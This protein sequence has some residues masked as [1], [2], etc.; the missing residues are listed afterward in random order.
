MARKVVG[1]YIMIMIR[2]LAKN[3][4]ALTTNVNAFVGETQALGMSFDNNRFYVIFMPI[5]G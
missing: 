2:G 3:L 1:D 5:L 4:N